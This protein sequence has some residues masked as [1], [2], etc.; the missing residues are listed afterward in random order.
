MQQPLFVSQLPHPTL[1]CQQQVPHLQ[2]APPHETETISCS[3]G[4]PSR[5]S[6][7]HQTPTLQSLN[8]PPTPTTLILPPTPPGGTPRRGPPRGSQPSPGDYSMSSMHSSFQ[9]NSSHVL[10]FNLNLP[11]LDC[12][13]TFPFDLL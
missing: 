9:V 6:G 4:T 2:D 7:Q 12:T 3:N 1:E 10:P 8:I 13:I 11:P 5:S